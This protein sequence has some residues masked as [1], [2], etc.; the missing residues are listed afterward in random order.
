MNT[1]KTKLGDVD[2]MEPRRETIL[3]CD[4]D[5][6]NLMMGIDVL[7]EGYEVITTD[8]GARM[9]KMLELITPDLILLDV[10]MPN[11][12]G[13]DIITQLKEKEETRNIPVIFLT[14]KTS[15]DHELKGLTL[16]AIDYITKPFAPQLLLKRIEVH[17]LVERQ[18]KELQ[19]QKEELVKFNNSLR[20]MVTAKTA[21]VIELQNAVMK[22]FS[23]L[24]ES[25]DGVTGDHIGRTQDYLRVLIDAMQDH[26]LYGSQLE[27][28][29]TVLILQSAQ[30]H[31]VGKIAIKDNILQKPGKLT[32][33]EHDTIKLH[34][35]FGETIIDNIMSNTKE[36]VF[37]EQARIL[38]STHHE[39]YPKGLKGREIPLLGRMMALVDVYDALISERPYKKARAHNE[40]V[41]IITNAKGKQF[42]PE[43][44]DIF[45][46]INDKFKA[47][48]L[49]E[50]D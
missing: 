20:E 18:R 49:R 30:L 24:I 27:E 19:V 1:I 12:S 33:D 2:D 4:D 13:Y 40:V 23:E 21:T 31:D 11:L 36:R 42:D 14:A 34:V 9:F 35:S 43:L 7:E 47:I 46:E 15:G 50:R 16:G 28:W 26:P 6:V 22:T 38:V 8:S 25:R 41:R 29:D 37:L 32:E 17:L 39:R 5:K 45:L 10:E 44:V 48:S 3:L